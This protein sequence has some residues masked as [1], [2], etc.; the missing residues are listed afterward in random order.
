MKVRQV[1]I[2]CTLRQGQSGVRLI[3][4]GDSIYP[5]HIQCSRRELLIVTSIFQA[6]KHQLGKARP[7]RTQELAPS[8]RMQESKCELRVMGRL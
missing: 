7:E 6:G 3:I 5:A 4:P 8:I 2:I 1:G